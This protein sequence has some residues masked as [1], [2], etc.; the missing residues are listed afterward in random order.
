MMS[1]ASSP[2]G[3]YPVFL[4]YHRN[5]TKSEIFP[6]LAGATCLLSNKSIL[7]SEAAGDSRID[8]LALSAFDL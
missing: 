4:L 3:L 2:S 5:G 8:G 6:V 7:P 1:V